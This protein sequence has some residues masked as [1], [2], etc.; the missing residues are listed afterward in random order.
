[1]RAKEGVTHVDAR[2]PRS[3]LHL[4]FGD[5]VESD[6]ELTGGENKLGKKDNNGRKILARSIKTEFG[7]FMIENP[8]WRA[9]AIYPTGDGGLE[10]STFTEFSAQDRHKH[11]KGIEIYTVLEGTLQIYINDI[12]ITLHATDEVVILPKTVHEVVRTEHRDRNS[13]E[14]FRLLVRVHSINC[15]GEH[16]K[17]VQLVRDGEWRCW[18]D[19]SKEERACAYKR[20]TED[21]V[22]KLLQE[23]QVT[24]YNDGPYGQVHRFVDFTTVPPRYCI[25][26]SLY[27]M[28]MDDGES[29]GR[30]ELASEMVDRLVADLIRSG[31]ATALMN[32]CAV[33]WE[34][35]ERSYY[36]TTWRDY[37]DDVRWEHASLTFV[38]GES[39][40]R[41]TDNI[42]GG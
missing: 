32:A 40:I 35:R 21:E 27:N 20:Q 6:A 39:G 9:P 15:H 13:S 16:D 5:N 17:Y 8:I 7:E 37:S 1:L 25:E 31:S 41:F 3:S 38:L 28:T 18:A 29:R 4:I 12:L 19:L 34:G 2:P 30:I 22:R 36:D 26:P 24:T 23:G 42:Y 33:H 11:E 14:N 10:V